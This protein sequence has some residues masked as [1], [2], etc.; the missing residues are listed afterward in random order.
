MGLS[1]KEARRRF[2]QRPIL[3]EPH[4]RWSHLIIKDIHGHQNGEFYFAIITGE[5]EKEEM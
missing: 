1:L 5:R 3:T 4:L 2:K